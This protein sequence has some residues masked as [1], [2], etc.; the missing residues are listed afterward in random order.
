VIRRLVEGA[1]LSVVLGSALLGRGQSFEAQAVHAQPAPM[2][3]TAQTAVPALIPYSGVLENADAKTPAGPMSMTFLIYKDEQGGEPL[4]AESQTIAV[5]EQHRYSATLGATLTKGLPDDLFSSGEARWLEVQV[6]G[7]APQRRVL[8]MSVPYALKAADATTLGGL[9][10]S[11]FALAGTGGVAAGG[12]T[13][14]GATANA[15]TNVTTTG[16]T[17]GYVPMF[18]GPS[19]VVNSSLFQSGSF[20]GVNNSA[21]LSTLDVN[22]ELIQ[23][24]TLLMYGTGAATPTAGK[25]SEPITFE[26][27][28]YNSSTKADVTSFFTLQSETAGNNTTYPYGTLHLLYGN[29]TTPTET[30]LFIYNSGIIHFAPNQTFNINSTGAVPI[31]AVNTTGAAVDGTSTSGPGA[32]GSSN[33]GNGMQGVTVGNTISTAG[34]YGVA[35]VGNSSGFSGIAGVWGDAA[36]HVGLLGT[37]TQYSGVQGQSANSYGVQGSSTSSFGV[38]G[39]SSNSY[40][41]YAQTNT[42]SSGIAA[43]YGYSSGSTVGVKGAS[44]SGNG[45]EFYGGAN[46]FGGNGVLAVGG[47]ASGTSGFGGAGGSFTGGASSTENG[48]VGMVSTGGTGK[49]AG[50]SG[51]QATG[52]SSSETGGEGGVFFGGS[53]GSGF[54]GGDGIF[55]SGGSGTYDGEAAYFEGDVSV[56]GTLSADAKNFQIDHPADPANKF[57]N[58]TAIE[59][60]E[61]VNIYSGNV[62]TDENGLATVTLPSWFESVNGDFRYQLTMG[63]SRSRAMRPIRRFPGR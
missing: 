16:G 58:H 3:A 36:N 43:M 62:T 18:N 50:G 52:G 39:L 51:M 24:G 22:G 57:L 56:A 54:Y 30:G 47:A 10:V 35:G 44:A 32:V 53:G 6:A 60:S 2:A 21:P 55:A 41:V 25:N 34:V 14:D 37:S 4:W 42:S 27:S 46:S 23:R 38:Y 48:G 61:M 26:A 9:P 29:N 7:R 20:L 63:R 17:S 13:A 40:G 33:T 1:I 45:G 19:S 49:Y 5:D 15:A 12:A 59:S 11:A 8:M 31:N 28:G